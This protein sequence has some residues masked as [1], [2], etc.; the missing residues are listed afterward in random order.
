M[1]T[2]A[3]FV[4]LRKLLLQLDP[5]S[6][7]VF[8]YHLEGDYPWVS[9][10]GPWIEELTWS[11][12]FIKLWG[13]GSDF[14]EEV[15]PSFRSRKIHLTDLSDLQ[16]RIASQV[17]PEPWEDSQRERYETLLQSTGERA[18]ALLRGDAAALRE[19]LDQVRLLLEPLARNRE[20]AADAWERRAMEARQTAARYRSLL[21]FLNN[22]EQ[23][24]GTPEKTG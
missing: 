7:G 8:L 17:P 18:L 10:H 24:N 1:T 23:T 21:H 5:R 13:P 19:T 22:P 3:Y 15:P 11:Q 6:V 20:N 4:L 2:G 14:D 9:A 12:L 16:R